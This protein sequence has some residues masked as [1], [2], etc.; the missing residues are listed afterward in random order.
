[1]QIAAENRV[2]LKCVSL[3]VKGT[4][5]SPYINPAKMLRL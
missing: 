2:V 3:G 1:M 4:V 5:F